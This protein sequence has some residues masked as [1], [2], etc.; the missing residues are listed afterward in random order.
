MAANFR[1]DKH[2]LRS[3]P[4]YIA[5]GFLLGI[6]GGACAT[7]DQMLEK[8]RREQELAGQGNDRCYTGVTEDCYTGSDESAGRGAC[9]MGERTCEK[10]T[11]SECVGEVIPSQ[12][13]CNQL[14][15]DCDGV[16]DNGF[17]RQGALCSY[18]GAK[19]AC[20][21]QG[22]W[23]CSEDGSKSECDAPIVKPVAETCNG[24]DDDCDGEMDEDSVPADQQPCSTGKAGVCGAG[25]NTCVKAN[26]RCV[27]NVQPG[28]EICNGLDD[29]CDNEVDNDC[30][31]E[32]EAAR[33]R[34]NK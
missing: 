32:A 1:T 21:T 12:D 19:G 22:K 28:P 2:W 11:W 34:A 5:G 6:I 3:V 8:K 17:E 7:S 25:T 18:E 14:D 13:I 30:V 24:V 33:I 9:R 20:K 26:V 4:L 27:Q 31:T 16:V 15:D 29:D 10:G 23:K